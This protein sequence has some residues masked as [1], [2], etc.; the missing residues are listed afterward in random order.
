MEPGHRAQEDDSWM[1]DGFSSAASPLRGAMPHT[2]SQ[3]RRGN[4]LATFAA[5]PNVKPISTAPLC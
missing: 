5:L 4:A 3:P 1:A 2:I